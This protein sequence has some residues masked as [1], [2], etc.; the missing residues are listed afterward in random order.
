MD[1]IV[2]HLPDED[3]NSWYLFCKQFN[4]YADSEQMD[5]ICF[6][7]RALKIS[8]VLERKTDTS[9]KTQFPGKAYKEIFSILKNNRDD[10]VSKIKRNLTE[11][12]ET[13]PA[14]VAD[15]ARFAH[16]GMLGNI[17]DLNLRNVDLSSVPAD[18][19]ASL[20]ACV[21]YRLG[22]CNVTSTDLRPLCVF[23]YQQADSRH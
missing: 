18:H 12:F 2:H 20:A 9:L 13:D 16:H 15:A 23:K 22:I 3:L 14:D 4:L 11:K 7:K 8:S 19:L 5:V 10:L 6:K 17:K 1:K 21:R